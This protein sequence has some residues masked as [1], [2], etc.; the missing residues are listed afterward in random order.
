MKYVIDAS[1]VASL[2]LPDEASEKTAVFARELAHDDAIAPSLLQLEVTNILLM[3]QRRKRIT[4]AQVKQLSDAFEKFP[5]TLQPALTAEQRSAVLRLA[6]KHDMTAYDA[7]YLELAMRL[8][9]SLATLDE[10]LIKASKIEGVKV[11]F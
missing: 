5:V 3:A 7:A 8:G 10:S 1:F 11:A 9:L 6:E 4:G 2:F